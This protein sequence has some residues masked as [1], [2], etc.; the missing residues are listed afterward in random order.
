M[1]WRCRFWSG[2]HLGYSSEIASFTS[3]IAEAADVVVLRERYLGEA[4]NNPANDGFN[5]G[6][7]PL[8]G[9]KPRT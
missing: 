9:F 7:F 5:S 1:R 4:C 6:G 8:G 3:S 2:G